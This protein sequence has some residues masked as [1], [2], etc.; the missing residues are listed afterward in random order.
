MRLWPKAA[1][2]VLALAT[3]GSCDGCRDKP[4]REFEDVPAPNDPPPMKCGEPK[5]TPITSVHEHLLDVRYLDK[6]LAAAD[7]AGTEAYRLR[8]GGHRLLRVPPY[9][10]V[11]AEAERREFGRPI[12]DDNARRLNFSGMR[13]APQWAGFGAARM[14]WLQPKCQI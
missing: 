3:L 2:V 8:I 10:K 1:Y 13:R 14:G 6:L 4:G 9:L 5:L 12:S 7:A 11:N